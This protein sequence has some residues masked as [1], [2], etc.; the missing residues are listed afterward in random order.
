MTLSSNARN[1][2]WPGLLTITAVVGSLAAACMM[3]FTALAVLSAATLP[4]RPAA[5]A[6]VAAWLFNQG[7]GFGWLGY[8]HTADAAFQGLVIGLAAL[9][10]L[11]TARAVRAE[12]GG[13]RLAVAFLAA[14]SVYELVLL[15]GALPTG[16]LWTF[17][18]RYVA[19]V[20]LTEALWFF[21]LLSLALLL[22]RLAPGLAPTRPI[23]LRPA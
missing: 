2:A 18:P 13:L 11:A 7:A 9:A 3:P 20:A 19:Q 8:P 12:R 1:P 6:V 16:G 15:A 23:R 17:A 5:T 22:Q 14:F 10:A 21:G 4:G